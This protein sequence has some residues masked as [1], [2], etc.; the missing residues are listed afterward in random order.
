MKFSLHYSL[1]LLFSLLTTASWSQCF[2]PPQSY[3]SVSGAVY[4][5]DFNKDGYPDLLATNS[6][7]PT[8]R[9]YIVLNKGDNSGQFLAPI[10]YTHA[11]Y[12]GRFIPTDLNKDGYTDL[13]VQFN[14]TVSVYLNKGDNT[15][16]MHEPVAY[17][18]DLTFNI[19]VGDFNGDG[20]PDLA[21]SQYEDTGG[22]TILKTFYLRLN[23]PGNPGTFGEPG[24]FIIPPAANTS[25][26]QTLYVADLNADGKAD[27]LNATEDMVYFR[28][29]DGTA[30]EAPVTLAIPYEPQ[31]VDI[32]HDGLIDI[33]DDTGDG[34]EVAF[35]QTATP[36]TFANAVPIANVESL[37]RFYLKDVNSDNLPDFVIFDGHASILSVALND[38][39][40]P[41]TFKEPVNTSIEF[42]YN[43]AEAAIADLNKD[44]LS[45]VVYG[46]YNK[47]Y[48]NIYFQCPATVQLTP[49]VATTVCAG[50]PVS[51]SATATNFTPG[52]YTWSSLPAGFTGSGS[53]T[54]LTA[55]AVDSPTTYTL[56][57]TAIAGDVTR[58]SS[59]TL[60]VQ[61][62]PAAP[63]PTFNG[64]TSATVI[65]NTPFVSLSIT[66]CAGGIVNWKETGGSSGTGTTISVP[67]SATGTLVYSATCTVGT[68]VSPPGSATITVSPSLVS[69]SFDGFVYGAD[70]STFRGWAWDRNKPNTAVSVDILDGPT[71]IA[72]V[73][74]DVFRQDLQTAGKGNGKHAFSW[75]IPNSLKDGLAH[76]L[77]ARVS[78]SSFLLKDSPKALIC[79][80]SSSPDNKAPVPPSPTVLI[81]P[82]AAQVGV[83]FSGTLVAF[84]DPENQPLTYALSGLPDGLAINM[85]SR[86]ISGTPTVAGTFVL[87]YS[88]SDG[89]LT[90]SVSFPLTVNPASTT[91]VTGDFEGYLDKLDCG[92]IRGW[93]WDRKKPNTPLTVE[94]Y[95]EGSGTVLGSTV[96]NIFRQDL[97]DAG[98]GNGSHAYNFTPP[99]SLTNGTLVKARV[100]GSTYELKGGAKA[101]QCAPARLSAETAPAL[102]VTVLGNPVS[103]QLQVEIRG[104]EGQSL[105]LKLTDASG[106]LVSQRQI[107]TA[108]ALEQQTFPV[109]AQP[110]GLLFLRVSNGRKTV[111]VKVLK[112]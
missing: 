72:T 44:G 52:S 3:S 56:T 78:G 64:V 34:F 54:T 47:N 24:N 84:T 109:V 73:V 106:R 68:C 107:E 95:L 60:L 104:A 29:S 90:N 108:Q 83:P 49:L 15:G 74:A 88:A 66:T 2:L 58:S 17:P 38:P 13:V 43:F 8:S 101:Y 12:M 71:V 65:Q 6:G 39:A 48:L 11:D 7:S 59:V 4:S 37:E 32:N 98:K 5:G 111:S 67:T 77:S 31:L 19:E 40:N 100:L 87:A 94:F 14:L 102:A 9:F 53:S 50:S 55:P 22:F 103:D 105:Q 10:E 28:T 97:K 27:L 16:A 26:G 86:V 61:P 25:Y 41:G 81:A 112:Q 82:L 89:V 18:F 96:A 99:G 110:A 92:G 69:G 30:F 20:L 63:N 23:D 42:E 46:N 21:G 79:Q 75:S 91:T 80:G 85:T 1:L 33:V 62:A 57:V 93:V 70:C 51:L 45:E 76:N 36:G 35:N